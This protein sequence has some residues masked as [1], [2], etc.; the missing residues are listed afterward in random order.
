MAT[1]DLVANDLSVSG[2]FQPV[3]RGQRKRNGR[4]CG[5]ARPPWRTGQ[6]QF[7]DVACHARSWS[8]RGS[9]HEGVSGLRRSG[10]GLG[11]QETS[12]HW[13]EW[14]R[15]SGGGATR[16]M[17]GVTAVPRCWLQA[18]ARSSLA[19]VS[20]MS[21]LRPSLRMERLTVN[22][23]GQHSSTQDP[24][25]RLV[26][27]TMKKWLTRDWRCP[28]MAATRRQCWLQLTMVT[29]RRRSCWPGLRPRRCL[30]AVTPNRDARFPKPPV[31]WHSALVAFAVEPDTWITRGVARV[32]RYDRRPLDKIRRLLALANT[33]SINTYS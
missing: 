23:P 5:S 22:W 24:R 16:L 28:V 30:V 7:R 26:E 17:L 1:F 2:G 9:C 21:L 25:W 29:M 32:P 31:P 19:W 12:H 13:L 8:K 6:S 15:R 11:R 3:T 14:Q 33:Q 27:A 10:S 20:A 4:R 18:K